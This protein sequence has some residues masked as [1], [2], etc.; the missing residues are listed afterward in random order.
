[1]PILTTTPATYRA[2]LTKPCCD[3]FTALV[4]AHSGYPPSVYLGDLPARVEFRF[5]PFCGEKIGDRLMPAPTT[6]LTIQLP[7]ELADRLKATA[8]SQARPQIAL[9]RDAL[10]AYLTERRTG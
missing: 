7:P 4:R 8:Q 10:E 3:L 6:Q 5:C 1:M 9:I 2:E